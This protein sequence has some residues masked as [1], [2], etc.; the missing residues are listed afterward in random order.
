MDDYQR[1]VLE[2]ITQRSVEVFDDA[3]QQMAMIGYEYMRTIILNNLP[4]NDRL[5]VDPIKVIDNAIEHLKAS[6]LV[7]ALKQEKAGFVS[8]DSIMKP[9][10]T[11]EN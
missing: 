10:S 1:K 3:M 4:T 9:K 8:I 11:M 2:K 6:K 5:I 7:H